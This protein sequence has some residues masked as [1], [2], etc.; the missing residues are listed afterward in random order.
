MGRCLQ[1]LSR[2]AS[3]PLVR[4][5]YE[6]STR[7]GLAPVIHS[8]NTAIWTAD[9]LVKGLRD[10][11]AQH[12]TASVLESLKSLQ[13][14]Y[15]DVVWVHDADMA[16]PLQL[17]NETLPTLE[18]LRDC[19]KIRGVG[20]TGY[21]LPALHTLCAQSKVRLDYAM[22]FGRLTL[23]DRSL[24]ESGQILPTGAVSMPTSVSFSS[25]AAFCA[26]KN[27]R[28]VNGDPLAMGMLTMQGP[29][30]WHPCRYTSLASHVEQAIKWC[31]D[32]NTDIAQLAISYATS[33][34]CT[35]SSASTAD[36]KNEQESTPDAMFIMIGGCSVSELQAN[37]QCAVRAIAAPD[38]PLAQ[39][40]CL[41]NSS[42]FLH[43]IK[44]CYTA[45]FAVS[46][47]W[48]GIEL[49]TR[50][51]EVPLPWDES[52]TSQGK[53]H[54]F[55]NFHEY[56][57]FHAVEARTKLLPPLAM[58]RL[59]VAK[60]RP[61]RFLVLDVGCNEGNLTVDLYLRARRELP[62]HVQICV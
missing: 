15:I 21:H 18:T 13:T 38:V 62:D 14:G 27:I 10:F 51:A 12:V 24:I 4:S 9:G 54:I 61:A 20:L 32:S 60:G 29:P 22:P 58:W 28:V 7:I 17:L 11:S 48:E 26:E 57:T 25:F 5:N 23:H 42:I 2:E 49:A 37:L 56:Y 34:T 55:G 41:I 59:W 3:E 31:T 16:D 36:T 47:H 50:T 1:A 43:D 44:K 19:G 8:E 52:P 6:L 30:A 35:E 39:A 46:H 45:P 40:R 53:G 33:K